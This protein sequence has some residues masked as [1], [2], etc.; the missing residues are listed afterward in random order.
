MGLIVSQ[1]YKDPDLGQ[2]SVR[3]VSTARRFIARWRSGVCCIT[4]PGGTTVDEY[5]KVVEEWKPKL[6]AARKE[7]AEALFVPG[8]HFATDDW[9]FEIVA[10]SL[11]GPR[12]VHREYKGRNAQGRLCFELHVSP[13]YPHDDVAARRF[14]RDFILK[15]AG[16]LG[17]DYLVGQ[18][19]EESARLGLSDRVK[20]W[21]VGRGLNRMGCCKASGEISLSRALMFLPRRL[22]RATITHE[23]AHLT[24]FDHSPA[25]YALWEQYLG[26]PCGP[27]RAEVSATL[28]KYGITIL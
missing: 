16:T 5:K 9:E 12:M 23:L 10:N 17:K 15:L 21:S 14:L 4:V 7:P 24:H 22:R 28:K 11:I 6:L 2:V 8:F 13:D 18:A 19:E 1:K 27:L 25:F 20:S 3:V 26:E